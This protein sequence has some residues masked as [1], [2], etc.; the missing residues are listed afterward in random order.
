M[1]SVRYIVADIDKAVEFYR[2]NLD[3][4]VDMHNPGKFAALLRD[5][6]CISAPQVLEAVARRA[7][8]RSRAGGTGSWSSPRSWMLLWTG[9]AGPTQS[10]VATSVMV[11][12]DGPS[13]LKIH[14]ET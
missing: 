13:C 3:F 1:A 9:C 4:K 7:A 12:L 2:D 10:S 5:D 6:P 14:R 8:I 11:E